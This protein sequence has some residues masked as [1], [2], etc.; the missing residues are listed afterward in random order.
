MLL[1]NNGKNITETKLENS[2]QPRSAMFSVNSQTVMLE[3]MEATHVLVATT[4]TGFILPLLLQLL[5]LF[6]LRL[7]M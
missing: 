4:V 3:A 2:Q 1:F 5:L 6:L 7:K